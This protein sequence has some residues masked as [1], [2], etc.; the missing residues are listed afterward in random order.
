M[1]SAALYVSVVVL[2]ER[3]R[4]RLVDEGLLDANA[5]RVR[6][7][8]HAWRFALLAGVGTVLS[9]GVAFLAG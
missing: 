7:S 2:S 6:L 5:L 1:A 3:A 8:G 9:A 4:Q